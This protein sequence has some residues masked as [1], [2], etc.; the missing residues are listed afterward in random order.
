MTEASLFKLETKCSVIFLP[1]GFTWHSLHLCWNSGIRWITSQKKTLKFRLIW[2]SC[3]V[4]DSQHYCDKVNTVLFICHIF[5]MQIW[6]VGNVTRK[7]G[8]KI[9]LVMQKI[10]SNFLDLWVLTLFLF[11]WLKKMSH[12]CIVN[13]WLVQPCGIRT[14]SNVID[15]VRP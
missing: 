1:T 4:C 2:F 14:C 6:A 5:W 11:Q 7:T 12:K 13:T 15:I 9:S 10:K 3:N 8:C